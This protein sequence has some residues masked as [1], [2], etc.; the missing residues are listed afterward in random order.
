MKI[1][2]LA[3]K[4]Y[5]ARV[6][7][8]LMNTTQGKISYTG[9][10]MWNGMEVAVF[11]FESTEAEVINSEIWIKGEFLSDDVITLRFDTESPQ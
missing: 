7:E 4:R 2:I 3:R 1:V 5:C 6:L 11:V 9:T 8:F 10:K